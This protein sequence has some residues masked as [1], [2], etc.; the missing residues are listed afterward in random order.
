MGRRNVI[1]GSNGRNERE[2]II[3]IIFN[4][5]FRPQDRTWVLA[6]GS[7]LLQPETRNGSGLSQRYRRSGA[8]KVH[9]PPMPEPAAH[10]RQQ[11]TNGSGTPGKVP[12]LPMANPSLLTP[13]QLK[14]K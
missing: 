11:P 8:V 9:G 3:I 1:G 5:F 4:T 14:P 6:G 2:T 7:G 13:T 10:R 12:N